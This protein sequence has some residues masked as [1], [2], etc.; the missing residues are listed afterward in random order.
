MKTY[1]ADKE[2]LEEVCRQLRHVV[3]SQKLELD[4]RREE[5]REKEQRWKAALASARNGTANAKA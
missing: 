1:V 2:R 4:S 5:L 3:E